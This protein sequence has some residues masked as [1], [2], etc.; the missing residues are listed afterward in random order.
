MKRTRSTLISAATNSISSEPSSSNS[1]R[2]QASKLDKVR[3]LKAENGSRTV[4]G[5]DWLRGLWINLKTEGGKCEINLVNNRPN[6]LFVEFKELFP[7][8]GRLVGHKINAQCNQKC[9]PKQQKGRRRIQCSSEIWLKENS[10][11]QSK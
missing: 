10:N 4:I 1:S 6:K 8:H 5:R 7:G 11:N 9:V 2:E 3:A